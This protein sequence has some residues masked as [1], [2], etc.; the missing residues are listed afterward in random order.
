MHKA[1]LEL[2]EG[3]ELRV[4]IT[5]VPY[6]RRMRVITEAGDFEFQA[7]PWVSERTPEEHKPLLCVRRN[8]QGEL[9]DP[10]D[11]N[12][13]VLEGMSVGPAMRT[14]EDISY[15]GPGYNLRYRPVKIE[16]QQIS[17]EY[18]KAS[19]AEREALYTAGWARIVNGHPVFIVPAQ[20]PHFTQPVDHF[21]VYG[22]DQV[23]VRLF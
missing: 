15:I 12:L 6:T 18:Q 17:L 10:M 16:H 4:S 11:A 7:V 23:P 3:A 8:Q 20:E 21:D 5:E 22:I 13:F 19:D 1:A 9:A 2:L 14:P